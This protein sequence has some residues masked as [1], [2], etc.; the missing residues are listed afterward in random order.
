MTLRLFSALELSAPITE[1]LAALSHRLREQ[2][3]RQSVR[4]VQPRHIHLTLKFYG[5]VKPELVTALQESLTHAT[6][7]RAPVTLALNGL[8]LFPNAVRPRVVWVGLGGEL[9][10]LG[11][12]QAAVEQGAAGLGFPPEAR[13]FTPHLTLGRV[14]ENLRPPDRPRIGAALR[15]LAFSPQ[16]FTVEQVALIRSELKPAGPVYTRLFSAPLVR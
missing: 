1:S 7:G 16:T 15:A 11:A 2:L 9:D 3:P 13:A 6:L 12:L 14:T 4:W 5:E 10:A 8:G